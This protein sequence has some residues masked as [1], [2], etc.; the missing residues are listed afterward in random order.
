MMRNAEALKEEIASLGFAIVKDVFADKQIDAIL[1][2]IDKADCNKPTFRKTVDL[3]A[4][5]QFFKEIPEAIPYVFIQPLKNI[6]EQL[7]GQGFFI[8]KSIYFDKPEGSNW[9]VSYH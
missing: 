1:S 5:R 2:A 8:V 9:F 4:I 7:F 3:F 6:M